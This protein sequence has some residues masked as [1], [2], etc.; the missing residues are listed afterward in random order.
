MALSEDLSMAVLCLVLGT[1]PERAT[2]ERG[3]PGLD[4]RCCLHDDPEN[5]PLLSLSPFQQLARQW[6]HLAPNNAAQV[7][8]L[9]MTADADLVETAFQ[10]TLRDL[11]LGPVLVSGDGKEYSHEIWSGDPP[12]P[13]VVQRSG[14]VSVTQY[15]ESELNRAFPPLP[16]LPYRP[17]VVQD[18]AG[19]HM[20]IVY[21]QWVADS[22]SICMLLRE[23]LY[24]L[25][26][27]AKAR[28]KL[29]DLPHPA[30]SKGPAMGFSPV[31]FF[32][33]I[34]DVHR[35][36][37]DARYLTRFPLQDARPP[38][39]GL[40]PIELEALQVS[41]L[42]M[43]T[44]AEG[45]TLNDLLIATLGASMGRDLPQITGTAW[46]AQHG[47]R[48]AIGTSIDLR[49]YLAGNQA[50]TFASLLAY[51]PV[52]CQIPPGN[53]LDMAQDV[54]R[55]TRRIKDSA[56]TA[57]KLMLPRWIARRTAEKSP[58]EVRAFFH[59]WAP[60]LAT[61]SNVNLNKTWVGTCYP[62][63]LRGYQR[64]G[65]ASPII[66]ISLSA[67]TLGDELTLTMV[68]Q[69]SVVDDASA[70]AIAVGFAQTLGSLV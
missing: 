66:P 38:H 51:V 44:R 29:V 13:L 70:E 6:E 60:L 19:C 34:R 64:M 32:K 25:I 47:R 37:R 17:F 40:Y 45:F 28:R 36:R 30:L 27:P 18:G 68:V 59:Q 65:A 58:E 42:L 53:L 3:F 10:S 49:P 41:R 31:Q 61:V 52:V 55:Q 14:D 7:M 9:E 39:I 22:V 48:L 26:E 54:A 1:E 63:P 50:E 5:V 24:R 12:E 4:R 15:I 46:P 11:G 43:R 67:S 8:L 35:W 2:A 57:R 56:S 62:K 16:A 69:Q 33:G 23:W 21:E 20:G